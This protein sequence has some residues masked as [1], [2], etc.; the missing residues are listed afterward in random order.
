MRLFWFRTDALQ[1][2]APIPDQAAYNKA[3]AGT[4]FLPDTWSKK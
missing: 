2:N 3:N 4:Q 1:K